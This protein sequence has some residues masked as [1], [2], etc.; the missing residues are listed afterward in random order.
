MYV[1][2]IDR[3]LTYPQRGQV[4]INFDAKKRVFQFSIPIFSSVRG[5]P[6]EIKKYVTKRKGVMF[7]PHETQFKLSRT[8]VFL[9]QEIPFSLDFQETIRT[10]ADSFWALSQ[11]CHRMFLEIAHEEKYKEALFLDG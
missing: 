10:K 6:G 2:I 11:N 4:K 9:F 1:G 8:D 5:L 3:L 7:K